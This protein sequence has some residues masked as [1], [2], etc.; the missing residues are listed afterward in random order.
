VSP[1]E[2][3][4][5]IVRSSPAVAPLLERWPKVAL[6]DGWIA[7]GAVAQSV[8]NA[9]FRLPPLHGLADVDLI[10]FDAADLSGE[11]EAAHA[12]RLRLLFPAL[13][14]RLDVKNEARVHLW[15]EARFGYPI[16]PYRSAAEAVAT[17]PTT[18]TAVA[19]RPA[20]S[21]MEILAPFGLDDLLGCI[22]RPNEAQITRAIYQAKLARWR[23]L[24]PGLTM[25]D[26]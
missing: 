25:I 1:E 19:V 26:W 6:P 12:E 3:L 15:Y 23:S 5:A 20:G 21:A 13:P 11:S 24:W 18:A 7:A 16:R 2:R 14:V 9:A 8:W 4:A 17:F 10:Y 22:V